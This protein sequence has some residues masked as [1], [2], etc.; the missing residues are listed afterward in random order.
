[1]VAGSSRSRRGPLYNPPTF[2]PATPPYVHRP[3]GLRTSP[4]RHRNR[5]GRL[6]RPA[7]GRRP[8][9]RPLRSH[10]GG[11]L[12]QRDGR[13][14]AGRSRSGRARAWRGVAGEPRLARRRH[15]RD[16]GHDSLGRRRD[17]PA[18]SAG[19]CRALLGRS[20]SG[21]RR[22][23]PRP[24]GGGV[25]QRPPALRDRRRSVAAG[26]GLLLL[27][28]RQRPAVLRRRCVGA[29]PTQARGAR[30]LS[31]PVRARGQRR[32]RHAADRRRRSGS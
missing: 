32:R 6:D 9:G 28:Q 10:G 29:L 27:H 16:A 1:M 11:A 18:S 4:R 15:R 7:H 19:G 31:Q 24:A 5:P 26:V 17:S 14:A 3:A 2:H 30:L 21:P 8:L 12:E 20:A 13:G 22:R 23:E 25:S